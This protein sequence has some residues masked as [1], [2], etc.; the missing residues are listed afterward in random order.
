[1]SRPSRKKS[2]GKKA[3]KRSA[4]PASRGKK[5]SAARPRKRA[6]A[7]VMVPAVYMV[8]LGCPKN[9]VDSERL[10]GALVGEGFHISAEAESADL[11]LVNTCAFLEPAC[12]ETRGVLAELQEVKARGR[13]F[14]VSGIRLPESGEYR[15]L[16]DT[17]GPAD[18]SAKIRLR[19]ARKSGFSL[20]D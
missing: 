6:R 2:S 1:M 15:L 5:R 12:E 14:V 3:R 17:G 16:V 8:S 11:A 9:Q 13:L 7:D 10:A 18:Y 19:I 4:K 20:P